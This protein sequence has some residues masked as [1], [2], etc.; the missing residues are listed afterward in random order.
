MSLSCPFSC[1]L[2]WPL[3]NLIGTEGSMLVSFSLHCCWISLVRKDRCYWCLCCV[4]S[5]LITSLLLQRR[6]SASIT[7][8]P[9]GTWPLDPGWPQLP[10]PIWMV[11][12]SLTPMTG[13]TM[14]QSPLWRTRSCV[15][16]CLC[17]WGWGLEDVCVC[18]CAYA[19]VLCW[20]L[21]AFLW[22]LEEC[23]WCIYYLCGCCAMK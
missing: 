13:E 12:L 2:N 22:L 3:M 21:C 4:F 15:C 6:N 8:P 23:S 18:G 14:G 10:R 19:W 16:V 20:F 7:W 9:S 1:L 5:S 17:V 11:M